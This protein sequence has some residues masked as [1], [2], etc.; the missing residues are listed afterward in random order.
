MYRYL[1][2][3]FD[4]YYPGGG[5][6]DIAFKTNDIEELKDFVKKWEYED[7]GSDYENLHV[8]DAEKDRLIYEAEFDV[9]DY[10]DKDA[11]DLSVELNEI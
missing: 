3:G 10:F 11:R 8:Y 9:H 7:K 1:V 6:T 4:H 5:M 2:F